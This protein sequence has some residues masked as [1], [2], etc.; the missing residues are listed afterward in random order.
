MSDMT[1]EALKFNLDSGPELF[2]IGC[3]SLGNVFVKIG[4]SNTLRMLPKDA[5][6]LADILNEASRHAA[7][8]NDV[9]DDYVD[10]YELPNEFIA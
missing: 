2:E 5:K 10:P 1:V 4:M 9:I 8:D 7:R 6:K 3:D